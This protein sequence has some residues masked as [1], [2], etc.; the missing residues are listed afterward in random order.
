[1]V[2][3]DSGRN[4]NGLK[5]E[6]PPGGEGRGRWEE[7]FR[8]SDTRLLKTLKTGQWLGNP[9]EYERTMLTNARIG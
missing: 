4:Q 9:D 8:E 5:V 1:M 3:L 7:E 2:V 6:V